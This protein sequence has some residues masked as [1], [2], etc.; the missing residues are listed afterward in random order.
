MELFIDSRGDAQFIYDETLDLQALGPLAIARASYV[1]PDRQGRWTADLAP[2]D[3]PLL[4]PFSRRTE[5]L[6]AELAWL[7]RYWLP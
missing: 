7:R 1:E 5:A 4:G 6:E 3:G 2:S